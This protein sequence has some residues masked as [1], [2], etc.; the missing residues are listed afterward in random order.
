MHANPYLRGIRF[1]LPDVI[2]RTGAAA[3]WQGMEGR[4]SAV[5][6]SFFE[7][8]PEA[9]LYL[10]KWILHDWDDVSCVRILK[11]CARAMPPASRMMVIEFDLGRLGEPSFAPLLDLSIMLLTGGR[12]RTIV[13]FE[14][15]FAAAGL[16]LVKATPIKPGLIVM[17]AVA[18]R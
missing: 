11:N 1:D 2:A 9:D 18:D 8:V 5:A 10:L 3:A 14:T 15:L 16:K 4:L 12:E 17:E 7:S 13:Q 6:G